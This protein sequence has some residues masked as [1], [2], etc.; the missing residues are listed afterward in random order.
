MVSILRVAAAVNKATAG[1]PNACLREIQHTIALLGIPQPIW[2]S[3]PS[4]PWPLR[5]AAAF[6]PPPGWRRGAGPPWGS[7]AWPPAAWTAPLW[8]ASPWG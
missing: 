3:F 5:T 2:L 4:W 1:D 6:S 7:C 8:W